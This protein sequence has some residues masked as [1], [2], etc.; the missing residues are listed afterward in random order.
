MLNAQIFHFQTIDKKIVV[1]SFLKTLLVSFLL[2]QI[3]HCLSQMRSS[4]VCLKVEDCGSVVFVCV[5]SGGCSS[6]CC[7]VECPGIL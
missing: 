3:V 7:Y 6:N 2:L 4:Q 5:C 1:R